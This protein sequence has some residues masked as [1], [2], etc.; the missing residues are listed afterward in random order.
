MSRESGQT[1]IEA[2]PLKWKSYLADRFQR[3]ARIIATAKLRPCTDC[4]G[5]FNHYQMDFD[6][7]RG[8]K[9]FNLSQSGARSVK[10]VLAE[11]KKCELVC[12]NCHRERTYKRGEY[13]DRV[14]P[15]R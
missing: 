14:K 11:L 6:H 9:K 7:V 8:E 1:W 4:Y 10:G 2:N 3:N 5:W 15:I 13:K 12:A